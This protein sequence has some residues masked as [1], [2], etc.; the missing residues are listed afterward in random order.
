M[1]KQRSSI[2]TYT[3]A[4]TNVRHYNWAINRGWKN[5]EKSDRIN[6]DCLE[7]TIGRNVDFK[8]SVA[9]YTNMKSLCFK[10]EANMMLYMSFVS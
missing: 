6:L 7:E 9:I 8:N 5:I 4:P 2:F 3:V 1:K 10:P